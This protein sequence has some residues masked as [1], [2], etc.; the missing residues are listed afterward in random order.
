MMEF[1]NRHFPPDR[2]IVQIV[3]KATGDPVHP[4][5]TDPKNG[6]LVTGPGYEIRH[7]RREN[8]A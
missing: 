7:M 3:D 4:V 2:H 6:H 8:V 1:G 5:L